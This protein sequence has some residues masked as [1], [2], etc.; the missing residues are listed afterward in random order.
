MGCGCKVPQDSREV[1]G[2]SLHV[3]SMDFVTP[4]FSVLTY[5]MREPDQKQELHT[6]FGSSFSISQFLK[7]SLVSLL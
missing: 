5:G 6:H 1:F 4:M 3:L 2:N 7:Q